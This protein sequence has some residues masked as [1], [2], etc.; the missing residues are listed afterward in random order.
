MI[1]TFTLP[2]LHHVLGVVANCFL[3]DQFLNVILSE[4]RLLKIE[5]ERFMAAGL[6]INVM[7]T[8]KIWV[9]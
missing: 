9:T 7:K 6:I 8:G 4:R 2:S 3:P 5:V 1:F